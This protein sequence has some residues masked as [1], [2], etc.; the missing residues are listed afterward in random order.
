M[1]SLTAPIRSV[2]RTSPRSPELRFVARVERARGHDRASHRWRRAR[3][4]R[5]ENDATRSSQP[6]ELADS[7]SADAW[8]RLSR[9]KSPRVF[10][11]VEDGGASTAHRVLNR[12][13]K[14]FAMAECHRQHAASVR[15]P[16]F[17]D[18]QTAAMA[19]FPP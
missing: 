2:T 3:S 9:R 1:I 8:L 11:N 7:G 15:S 17:L 13:Q 16:E 10:R 6:F 5:C 18:L 19:R 12:F 4:G 14:N